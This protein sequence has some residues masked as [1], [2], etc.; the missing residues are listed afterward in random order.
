MIERFRRQMR[1]NAR[2]SEVVKT[3][4][5]EIGYKDEL[6]RQYPDANEQEARWAS[7]EELVNAVA[8]YSA[9]GGEADHR[10]LLAGGGPDRQRSRRGQGVEAGAQRRGADDPARG[11]GAGVPRGLHGRH[12]RRDAAAPPVSVA[13]PAARWTR[14]GGCAT[15]G[16]TRAQRRLTLTLALNRRKW[17]KSRPTHPS[18]FLYELTGQADNPN[19]QAAKMSQG[20][21]RAGRRD[22]T[23]TS[24]NGFL[25]HGPRRAR[26]R[27]GIAASFAGTSG[28][29][30]RGDRAKGHRVVRFPP[31]GDSGLPTWPSFVRS[32]AALKRSVIILLYPSLSPLNS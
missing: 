4:I 28:Q 23:A 11:Q 24:A 19:Y 30:V 3:L 26:S 27:G 2:R 18:R 32:R 22:M 14:N 10:R 13:E 12:G 21:Q 6:T 31:I 5:R 8:G 7:V 1:K 29:P 15:S 9:A 25:R 16:V 17:G 20:R